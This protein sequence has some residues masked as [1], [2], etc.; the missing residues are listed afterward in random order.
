MERK[1]PCPNEIYV[2]FKGNRYKVIAIAHHSETMEEMVVY[3]ALYGDHGVYVRPLDMFMSPVDHEKYPD[4]KAACRFE[5][6]EG[7]GTVS[8]LIVQFLDLDSIEHKMEF[9]QSHRA[10]LDSGFLDAAAESIDFII[11]DKD[12]DVKYQQLM[13]A[14]MTRNKYETGRLR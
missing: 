8:P 2:H 5:L 13:H 9:I 1:R 3:E 10:Q 6:E 11:P 7:E 4:V 14:L 12:I